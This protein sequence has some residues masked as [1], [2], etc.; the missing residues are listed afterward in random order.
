MIPSRINNRY[1]VI[2]I[3]VAFAVSL[4]GCMIPLY[5]QKG[6]S[7]TDY[8]LSGTNDPPAAIAK[9][10]T[11]ECDYHPIR[12][13]A[14]LYTAP[15]LQAALKDRAYQNNLNSQFVQAQIDFTT[16]NLVNERTVFTLDIAGASPQTINFA[17]WQA[18]LVDVAGREYPA[19]VVANLNAYHLEEKAI[20]VNK[21]G[22]GLYT[23]DQVTTGN[24]YERTGFVVGP[25]IDIYKG[26]QLR[27]LARFNRD[28]PVFTMSWDAPAG[29]ATGNYQE[30]LTPENGIP[31]SMWRGNQLVTDNFIVNSPASNWKWTRTV[32]D[33]SGVYTEAYAGRS[34]DKSMTFSISVTTPS[35]S[36]SADDFLS[37][38]WDEMKRQGM[39]L[40]GYSM[41]DATAP[42]ADSKMA[43]FHDE[44]ALVR[45]YVGISKGVYVIQCYMSNSATDSASAICDTFA[46]SFHLK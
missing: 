3:A 22:N 38:Y 32:V 39:N 11:R 17:Q 14:M 37:N 40:T 1:V 12:T 7:A 19:D 35:A 36:S 4:I 5:R 46:S 15:Y 26:I 43:Q 16:K 41:S 31:T 13:I 8:V 42:F 6:I 29:V 33:N 34:P 24:L 9:D 21:V 44:Q 30:P 45:M 2:T 20:L 18:T 25:H 23:A 27:L 10:L 28:L